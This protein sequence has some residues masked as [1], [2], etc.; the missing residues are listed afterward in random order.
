MIIYRTG[1]AWGP[2]VDANLAPA[3]VDG[4]FYDLDSRTK[5]LELHPV[6]PV[7]ITSF[8]S[9]GNQLYIYM[10][11]GSVQGPV[12]LPTQKWYFRGNWAPNTVYAI[13]DVFSGPDGGAYIVT[14]DH[15]SQ[16]SFDPGANDGHGHDY[17]GLLL[18]PAASTL[19]IGGASGSVLTK[20]S[21]TDF[22]VTWATIPIPPGGQATQ[23]LTK[24][25]VAPGDGGW[26]WPTLSNL[27]DVFIGAFYPLTDGDYL[28]WSAGEGRWTNQPRPMSN[29]V[30]AS[31]WDPVVGDE[32]TFMVLTNDTADTVITIP[33]DSTQNFA[34]GS[35]L[36]VHQDGTGKVT[37]VGDVGVVI[38]K[39]ASF[40]AQLLGQYATASVKKTAANEWRLFGLLSGA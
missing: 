36:H 4:N 21:D 17:Y 15:T 34:I 9:V 28:R 27:F 22:A 39:H 19:P 26:D 40:A 5:N 10:S 1:G 2:G 16:T 12:T 37:I 31:S 29:V 38:L 25:S 30:E 3:Q 14:Y 8:Q 24:F 23:V 35:E 32:G 11:D 20:S 18:K 6:Q 33:N 13:D 7:Q